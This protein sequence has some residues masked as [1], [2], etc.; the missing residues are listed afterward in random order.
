MKTQ[1]DYLFVRAK[2]QAAS[3]L[4][5]LLAADIGGTPIPLI[6]VALAGTAMGS[7]LA[8]AGGGGS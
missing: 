1:Q 7:F 6:F 8:L 4:D 2:P 3:V 5:R